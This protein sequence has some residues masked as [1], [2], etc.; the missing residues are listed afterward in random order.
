MIRSDVTGGNFVIDHNDA[1]YRLHL[2]RMGV[3]SNTECRIHAH[4]LA[5]T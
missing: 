5:L 4:D 1:W 3:E 2:Q